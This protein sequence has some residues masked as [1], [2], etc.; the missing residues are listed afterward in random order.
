MRHMDKRDADLK[1]KVNALEKD[2]SKSGFTV[3]LLSLAASVSAT[4]TDV[5]QKA[6]EAVPTKTV[7]QWFK[8][9]I[10]QSVQSKRK[11]VKNT[12]RGAEQIWDLN[13]TKTIY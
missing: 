4:T 9:N 10:G 12:V 5:V 3:L 13:S 6:M 11:E 2:Q 8:D 7:F 1:R